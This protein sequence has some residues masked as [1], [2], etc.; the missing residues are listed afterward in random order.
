MVI[1]LVESG[2]NERFCFAK[3]YTID[4]TQGK[5]TFQKKIIVKRN[6]PM[7]L[8]YYTTIF[9]PAMFIYDHSI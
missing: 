7:I 5:Y 1:K 4:F 2:I 9:F 8:K 3:V 6:D